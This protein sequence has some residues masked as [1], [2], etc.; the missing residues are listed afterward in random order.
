[1]FA[2]FRLAFTVPP[3]DGLSLHCKLTRWIVLQKARRHRTSRLRLLVSTQFQGLFHSPPGDLFTFPSRYSFTIDHKTYLAL[4]GGPPRF[5]Q[6]STCPALLEKPNIRSASLSRTRLSRPLASHSNYSASKA[7][8]LPYDQLTGW[9]RKKEVSTSQALFPGHLE[10]HNPYLS[11]R[12]STYLPVNR[13]KLKRFG[14]IPFRSPLLW[15]S[16]FTFFS[17]T[18]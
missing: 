15:D 2:L 13:Q 14:L 6:G 11:I 4:G 3:P 1:M 18:Y 9:S 17:S 5:R 7:D 16:L 10:T 8:F 12:L